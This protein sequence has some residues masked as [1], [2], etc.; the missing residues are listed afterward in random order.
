MVVVASAKDSSSPFGKKLAANDK[1]TRDKAVKALG[2]WVS[3]K[4]DF[5]HLELMKMWKG[6]FYCV[7]MSDK[8]IV[9]Q[10]LSETLSS[11]IIR[12]P[13]EGVMDFIATFW[14]TMCAEWHGIDRLRL[15]KFYFLLRR[16]LSYSFRMLKE[17]EWELETIEEFSNVMINGPLNATSTKVPDGIRF[18]LI[19][20]YL[21]EL[22]KIV[23]VAH[24]G[25]VPTAHILQ[26][27]FHIL[28]H[29]INGKVFKMVAE[30]VFE[31]IL[32][33]T[34]AGEGDDS[35]FEEDA[36]LTVFDKTEDDDEDEDDENISDEEMAEDDS[37]DDEEAKA[38]AEMEMEMDDEIADQD[39]TTFDY[40]LIGIKERLSK[41]SAD[42]ETVEQNRR[43]VLVLYKAYQDFCPLEEDDSEEGE[44]EG[45]ES[46]EDEE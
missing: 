5:T 45:E 28:G 25:E 21:E 18:H 20:I 34:A 43:K 41:V 15:D 40:D 42:E 33:K 38:Q 17:N 2:K 30:E 37:D 31:S 44:G 8:P 7:W 39:S 23:D 16:F 13:R 1:K 3:K 29:T 22:E 12:V 32:K 14:E 6:L 35:D 4:K 36:N 27:M 10:Q 46:E 11:L 19:E 26:P 9:Q 24:S